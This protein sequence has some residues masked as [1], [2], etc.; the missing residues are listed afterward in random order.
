MARGG[1]V[2]VERRELRGRVRTREAFQESVVVREQVRALA[3][4]AY[5][6]SA[7]GAPVKTVGAYGYGLGLAAKGRPAR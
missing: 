5:A 4:V 2:A 3:I 1:L 6:Y 7:D